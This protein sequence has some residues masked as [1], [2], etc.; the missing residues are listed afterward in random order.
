M[1]VLRD[2]RSCGESA[3]GRR[4]SENELLTGRADDGGVR[5]RTEVADR[6]RAAICPPVSRREIRRAR[7]KLSVVVVVLNVFPFTNGRRS[8]LTRL[9]YMFHRPEQLLNRTPADGIN[10]PEYLKLLVREFRLTDSAGTVVIVICRTRNHV[11]LVFR[12]D[13]RRQVLANLANFAYDPVNYAHIRSQA[14]IDLFVEQLVSD[15]D[16]LAA[17]A[18]AGL[19]NL[20]NGNA[21]RPYCVSI[22]T[23]PC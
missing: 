20:S 15:D 22:P 6:D 3:H 10:R 9:A 1:R 12:L 19:C 7:D 4:R 8:P 16:V 2:G 21:R 14:V 23:L 5:F 13:S 18:A 17:Y 11:F